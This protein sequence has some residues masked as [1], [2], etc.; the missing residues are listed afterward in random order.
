MN[1]ALLV[2]TFRIR[3]RHLAFL[4]NNP[5]FVLS[6]LKMAL[7]FLNKGRQKQ[8]RDVSGKG[9]VYDKTF[10]AIRETLRKKDKEKQA[11]EIVTEW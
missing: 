11:R 9:I 10:T 5:T 4:S 8:A 3:I 2:V 1:Y 6:I 7:S